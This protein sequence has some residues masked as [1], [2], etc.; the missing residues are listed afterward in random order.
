MAEHYSFFD[1]QGVEGSYDR[2]YSSAD[3]AAYFAS[4]IGNGSA[5]AFMQFPPTN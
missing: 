1:A 5:T 4:F 2:T 3:V